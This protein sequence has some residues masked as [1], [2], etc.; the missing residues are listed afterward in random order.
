MEIVYD[1][2]D[3]CWKIPYTSN[4]A[5]NHAISELRT[6]RRDGQPTRGSNWSALP[7]LIAYKVIKSV[8]ILRH[9]SSNVSRH[10]ILITPCKLTSAVFNGIF[11]TTFACYYYTIMKLNVFKSLRNSTIQWAL[12]LR[13][14]FTFLRSNVR[15]QK[16]T[17]LK[18]L[19]KCFSMNM[20]DY[21]AKRVCES[22]ASSRCCA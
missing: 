10:S 2:R 3:S 19:Y 5:R 15:R 20:L 4:V 22:F 11:S 7:C 6:G 13:S 17:N 8:A 9:L 1:A 16:L 12:R 21:S 14:L 18:K